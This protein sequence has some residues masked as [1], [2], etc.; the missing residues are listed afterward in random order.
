MIRLFEIIDE[1]RDRG[2]KEVP[3]D[4]LSPADC[5]ELHRR[6]LNLEGDGNRQVYVLKPMPTTLEAKDVVISLN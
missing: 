1:V 6:G 2:R 3:Y 4:V 5:V